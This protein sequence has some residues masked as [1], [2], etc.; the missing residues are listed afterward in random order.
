MSCWPEKR[1][2]QK[3]KICIV[4]DELEFAEV[5]K[6]RLELEGFDVT[7]SMD[8]Y[9][10][11]VDAASST[12]EILRE[13][14]DLIILDLMMPA[15]GGFMLLETIRKHP[16]KANIPVVILT[17]RVID[18]DVLEKANQYKVSAIFTK[19]YDPNKFINKIKKILEP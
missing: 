14:H 19:P 17:G 1:M 16:T 10:G 4:E 18:Q 2:N 12:K 5:V 15:G 7:I 11:S 8:A 3:Y 9:S 13:N 6:T